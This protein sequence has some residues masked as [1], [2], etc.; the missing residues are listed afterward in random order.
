MS[1]SVAVAD[2]TKFYQRALFAALK[3][4]E[5]AVRDGDTEMRAILDERIAY[6]QD[7][8]KAVKFVGKTGMSPVDAFAFYG[9]NI[10]NGGRL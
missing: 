4:R 1:T 3:A 9:I 10:Q 7:C 6:T 2:A 8:I 5:E